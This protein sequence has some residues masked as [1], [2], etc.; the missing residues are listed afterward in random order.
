MAEFT[1]VELLSRLTVALAPPP[2]RPDES[3]LAQLHAT[4]EELSIEFEPASIATPAERRSIRQRRNVGPRRTV[5][6]SSLVA[7]SAIACALAAGVA[8]AAVATN[9]LPGPTR[10]FAY[11]IG[12]PVTS[13]SLFAA[14]RSAAQLKQSI[15][16]NN[17]PREKVLGQQLIGEL[18]TLDVS[19]LSQIRAVADTLLAD[20][21]LPIPALPNAPTTPITSNSTPTVSVPTATVPSVS[22]PSV[23]VPSVSVPSVTVPSVSTPVVTLPPVTI[24]KVSTPS[25]PL[26]VVT[27]PIIHVHGLP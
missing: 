24:P 14:Q 17:L 18:K 13:P 9:T 8:A 6:R 19:D 10:A 5:R 23:S 25:I 27:I 12:L 16:S 1:D 3:A 7:A 11:D 26:P 2:V 21:G 20:V 4:L 15:A 22:V